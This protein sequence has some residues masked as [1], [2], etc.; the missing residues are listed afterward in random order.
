M[1][2]LIAQVAW[3]GPMLGQH[4][5]FLLHI[6]ER[7][8]YAATRYRE[9]AERVYHVLNGRLKDRA[10]LA[11]ENYSIA[12]I[13]TYHWSGYAGIQ[14]FDWND[15]PALSEWRYRVSERP[16]VK[17][18]KDVYDQLMAA[19][20]EDSPRNQEDFNRF[21]ARKTGPKAS[22]EAFLKE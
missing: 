18:A 9:Q 11:G 6:S 16:A 2:W 13:A 3:V 22:F 21:F 14:G 5:H 1:K 12:D 19:A 15:F 4:N 8:S 17:R 7:E 20:A 10:Y